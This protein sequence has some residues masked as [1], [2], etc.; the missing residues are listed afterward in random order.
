MGSEESTR[1]TTRPSPDALLEKAEQETRG[2]L[3]IFLGAAPGVGKTYEMLLSGRARKSDGDDVVIGVVETHGR[4]ET[5]ALVRGFEIIPRTKIEYKGRILEEMDLDAVLE[6]G[7]ALVLVDELAHTNA[8]GS[9][10]PK[11]YLDV[12]ELLDHGIDVYTT[13][14]IQHLESLNDVVAQITRI[15]VRETLP[16]SILQKADDVEIIDIT[17]DDLIKR[18][19]EGKVYVPRTAKRAIENYFSPRNLTALRELA[20]RQTAQ[21]VDQQLLSQMRQ[22]AIEGP[23]PAGERILVCVN[24]D[25]CSSG[26]VRYAKRLADRLHAPWVALHVEGRRTQSLDDDGRDRIAAALR[27]AQSLEGD[28]VTVPGG[29]GRVAADIVAYARANNITH[30]VIGKSERSRWFEIL[31]GSVVHELVR[32]AG[33]I[34]VDVVA[35]S[36]PGGVPASRASVAVAEPRSRPDWKAYLKATMVVAMAVGFGL[37]LWPWLGVEHIALIFLTGVVTVAVWFGLLPSLYA[38]VLSAACYNFFFTNPYHTFLISRPREIVSVVFFTI[39]AVIVSNVAARARAQTIAAKARARTTEALYSFSRKLAGASTLDDVLWASA[40]QMASML[41]ARIIILLPENGTVAVRAGVPPDDTLVDAD[42]AAARWALEHNRPAGRGADTLPGAARLYVPLTTGETPVG[43]VGLDSDRQG[44]L[45]TPEEQRLLDALADQAAV[46]IERIQLVADVDKA[47]LAAEADKLRSAL[48]ASISHDLKTPLAAILGAAGNLRDYS[49]ALSE[50]DRNDM[51]STIVDESERL[52]RFIANLL[53]MSRIE[54]GAMEPNASLQYLDDMVGSALRRAQ[55]MLSRHHVRTEL[56]ADLPML[57][58][59][60]VL[61]EQVIFN[62]LDNAAKYAPPQTAIRM[63][64][65]K[66]GNWV[67]IQILDEGPGIPPADL[68]RVFD[69]FHRARKRDHVLAG[70]GLGLSIC[71]GFVEAMGGT[72]TSA[73][74]TDRSG[75]VFTIRMPTPANPP[76]VGDAS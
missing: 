72:I 13:L 53:D 31:H 65:W 49:A 6:R 73:N 61:F 47:R 60:P 17:P 38:S 10:H 26:L 74:R 5:E 35:G 44:P 34:S 1:D 45:L 66:D 23:W 16:D 69:S 7:P 32:H 43:V 30:I 24:E 18:L 3:K 41:K 57:K 62:L 56:P 46:A 19:N 64:A 14:N 71:R 70:T 25:P 20:L 36:K 2:R 27:L 58:V 50:Q 28:A 75:A 39:V 67:M 51:L 15:R 63:R 54:T 48:L 42:I 8:P 55:K 59:D 12:L 4:K 21:R 11:R 29:G 52:N 9:R 22:S 33:D 68:E 76:R 37:A 40:H